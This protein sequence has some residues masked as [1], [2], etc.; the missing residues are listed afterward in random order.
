MAARGRRRRAFRPRLPGLARMPGQVDRERRSL[1][2]LAVD[3]DEAVVLLDDAVDRGQP[4]AGALADV[5]GGEERLEEV[6]QRLL[7]HAAAVVAHGQQHVLA[8]DEPA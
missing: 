1:A 5:L 2:R 6:G 8:G 7:V 3:V 4:E